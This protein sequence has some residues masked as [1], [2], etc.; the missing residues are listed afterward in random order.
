MAIIRLISTWL[1]LFGDLQKSHTHILHMDQL[2]ISMHSE[3]ANTK[4]FVKQV[5]Y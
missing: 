5:S 2:K 4:Q 3:P 1:G